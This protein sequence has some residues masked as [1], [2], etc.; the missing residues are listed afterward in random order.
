VAKMAC[1][2]DVRGRAGDASPNA[3]ELSGGL[4]WLREAL[5]PSKRDRESAPRP[6]RDALRCELDR[7]RAQVTLLE[8]LTGTPLETLL[9]R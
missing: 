3:T 7:R 9:Q 4:P 6:D 5:A 1:T 8:E 2:W